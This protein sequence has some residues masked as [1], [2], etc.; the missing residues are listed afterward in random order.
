MKRSEAIARI[1]L[2]VGKDLRPLAEKFGVTVWKENERGETK[3]NKGWAGHTIER[4]LGLP[5]S[6]SR[7]P[8]F[9]SWELKVVPLINRARR[10]LCVKETMAITMLDPVEVQA[11]QFE[12]SH[13]YIKLRKIVI[14]ARTFESKSETRSLLHSVGTFDLNDPAIYATVKADYNLVRRALRT[15]GFDALT[16]AMGELIQPRTKGPGHGSTSRAFYARTQ[17]VAFILGLSSSSA[18]QQ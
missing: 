13:L 3:I 15:K 10:G 9:G 2:L 7:S 17:F 16:G 12:E 6:S 11:K 1:K 5:L 18:K 4:Y 14:V 8:N